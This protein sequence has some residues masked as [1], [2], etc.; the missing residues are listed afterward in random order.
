MTLN[1]WVN[2]PLQAKDMNVYQ[3]QDVT[4]DK[5]VGGPITEKEDQVNKDMEARSSVV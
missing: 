4:Y 2:L 1:S 3:E 5:W